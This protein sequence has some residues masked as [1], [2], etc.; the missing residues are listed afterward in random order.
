MLAA[1][2][3]AFSGILL[4]RLLRSE[5]KKEP[6]SGATRNRRTYGEAVE[7]IKSSGSVELRCVAL[8][9][10]LLPL[11][12]HDAGSECIF[13]NEDLMT[14]LLDIFTA[15][16]DESE[17]NSQTFEET[18]ARLCG[19]IIS[20]VS[21][22]SKARA[23]FLE[24]QNSRNS[25]VGRCLSLYLSSLLLTSPTDIVTTYDAGSK[26]QSLFLSVLQILVNVSAYGE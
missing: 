21:F 7:I 3:A 4:W 26:T 10:N 12:F 15:Q 20:N 25:T 1:G 11:T 24:L 2:A 13:D 18:E 6:D 16:L 23:G 19:W 22:I 9:Q 14:H 8:E 17:P 5:N